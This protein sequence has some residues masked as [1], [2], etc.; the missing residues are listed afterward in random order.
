[1]FS[2][3][4]KQIVRELQKDIPLTPQPFKEI[5]ERIGISEEELLEKVQ[6]MADQGI[7]RR[8]GVALKHREVGFLANAM[9]VWQVPDEKTLEIGKIM[10][11]FPQVSHCYQRPK[12]PDWPYNMFTM[13]HGQSREECEATAARIAEKTGI[14]EFGLLYSTDELKKSSMKYFMEE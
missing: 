6:Q 2:E 12:Y 4:D 5:A 3:L 10:A 9:V 14:P 1:M 11:S 13:V 7:I 8:F